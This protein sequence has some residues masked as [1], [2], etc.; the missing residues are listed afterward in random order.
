VDGVDKNLKIILLASGGIDSTTLIYDL[1]SVGADVTL[2]SCDYGQR[3]RR[4]LAA[5]AAV[6]SELGLRRHLVDL[7][8]VGALLSGG[9]LTDATVEVPDGYYTDE[10]MRITVVPNRNALMLDVA[11]AV[12]VVA[13][14]DAVA[15]APHA[16]DHVVYPDCRPGF[17]EAF[18][19]SARAANEGYLP[20]G[21]AVL[22]PYLEWTKTDIIRRGADLG[23]PFGLTWSCYRG[24]EV[25]CGACGTC[26]ER[27]EA[28][29]RAGVPDL[30]LYQALES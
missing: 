11:V 15:F 7:S 1:R 24:G 19:R 2:V 3:H 16:G 26:V 12:A 14:A 21:F 30:T 27:R 25:H 5:V 23:V 17:V 13:K 10:S 4:E 9:A 6:A 22:A 8:S 18:G 29:Q 28:F 20:D